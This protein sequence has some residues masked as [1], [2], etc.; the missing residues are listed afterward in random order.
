MV[1][2]RKPST[3]SSVTDPIHMGF[4]EAPCNCAMSLRASVPDGLPWW[5]GVA[6]AV[7]VAVCRLITAYIQTMEAIITAV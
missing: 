2:A 7:E 1:S 6:G 5:A 4:D 3:S